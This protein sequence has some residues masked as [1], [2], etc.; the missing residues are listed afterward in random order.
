M[1]IK[2][3]GFDRMAIMKDFLPVEG[4]GLE[5]VTAREIRSLISIGTDEFDDYGIVRSEDGRLTWDVDKMLQE[6]EF[7][8]NIPQL[9]L[10]KRQTDK[11]D[12]NKKITEANLDAYLKI[13]E[14]WENNN[15]KGKGK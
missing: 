12:K 8:L 11:L 4:D 14:V 7:D 13:R 9:S 10:L 3:S 6:K 2:L 5:M 1:E 15:G